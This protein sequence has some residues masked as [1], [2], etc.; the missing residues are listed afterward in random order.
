MILVSGADAAEAHRADYSVE[1]GV[2]VMTG[3]ALLSQGQS[4][5]TADKI[6]VNLD[7]GTAQMQG[8]V[9]TI[10]QTGNN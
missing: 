5:I 1:E 3:N 7:D 8:R 2:I 9:K 4:A 6:T 10:L